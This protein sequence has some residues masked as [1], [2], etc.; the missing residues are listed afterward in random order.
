[1]KYNKSILCFI[2]LFVFFVFPGNV[3]AS[4]ETTITFVTDI[5][6]WN[7]DEILA[8]EYPDHADYELPNGVT[9]KSYFKY[10]SDIFEIYSGESFS[11]TLV[12]LDNYSFD[13]GAHVQFVE[14]FDFENATSDLGYHSIELKHAF[15]SNY[16]I[17]S[18]LVIG[19]MFGS[20]D[21]YSPTV[22]YLVLNTVDE[23]G[24]IIGNRYVDSVYSS[25]SDLSKGKSSPQGYII[26]PNYC[27]KYHFSV[28]GNAATPSGKFS[29]SYNIPDGIPMNIDSFM[30]DYPKDAVFINTVHS[31]RELSVLFNMNEDI[32]SVIYMGDDERGN[33]TTTLTLSNSHLNYDSDI[34]TTN[35]DDYLIFDDD[36]Y[37]L[38]FYVEARY[39]LDET[40]TG[41]FYNIWPFVGI[42][43]CVLIVCVG[44]VVRNRKLKKIEI[45]DDD[46]L[47]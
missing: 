3:L 42:I 14:E 40:E 16:F 5:Y 31:I 24:N 44:F 30:V 38:E 32:H 9:Y 17:E 43:L 36:K 25:Y 29:I 33:E 46:N 10:N 20:Y 23:E 12:Y 19:Y 39:D 11:D 37:C 1:M 47:E 28:R 35:L 27:A 2:I 13:N 26:M 22:T 45:M 4:E 21:Y 34:P 41:V 7:N 15:F 8:I 6:N 18:D